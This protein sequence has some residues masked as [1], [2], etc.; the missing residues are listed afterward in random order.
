MTAWKM[1][2]SVDPSEN[3]VKI[4]SPSDENIEENEDI[5]ILSPFEEHWEHS[6]CH[7]NIK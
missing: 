4:V 5:I 2:S 7:P 6:G 3:V 1:N